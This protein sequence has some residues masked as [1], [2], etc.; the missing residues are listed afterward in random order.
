M[1]RRQLLAS[2]LSDLETVVGEDAVQP[3]KELS[4]VAGKTGQAGKEARRL[5]GVS[6]PLGF[7][8]VLPGGAERFL[9]E[10]GGPD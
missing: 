6:D 5:S 1:G 9:I 10:K 2:G 4:A 3:V 7:E 8:Q